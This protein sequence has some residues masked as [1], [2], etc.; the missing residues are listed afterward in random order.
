MKILEQTSVVIIALDRS[1]GSDLQHRT[2]RDLRLTVEVEVA[3]EWLRKEEPGFYSNGI[4][5][6]APRGANASKS[7]GIIL[8]NNDA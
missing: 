2:G 3:C 1:A 7:S 4:L 8:E 6:F 5:K